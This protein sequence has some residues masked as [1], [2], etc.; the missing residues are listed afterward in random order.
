MHHDEDTDGHA[1]IAPVKLY[2]AI[3]ATLLVLT[4][5]TLVAYQVHLGALNLVIAIAIAT[6]KATLV[7]MYFMHLRWDAKFNVM[8]LLGA[9]LFA[10]V[11]LAYTL[12]DTAYRGRVDREAG[13]RR[14][15]VTGDYAAGSAAGVG[16]SLVPLE[17]LRANP[18]EP[19]AE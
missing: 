7:V 12:N 19:S 3:L 15:P 1:H 10:G 11:F 17:Q 8:I 14:S 9:L 13:H 16:D 18:A 5:L 6:A 2:G 4:G